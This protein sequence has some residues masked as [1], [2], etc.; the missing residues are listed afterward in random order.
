[1]DFFEFTHEEIKKIFGDIPYLN[2]GGVRHD[3]RSNMF[4][5]DSHAYDLVYK[6][7]SR[8][9]RTLNSEQISAL[10]VY[11]LHALISDIRNGDS[12]LDFR[13]FTEFDNISMGFSTIPILSYSQYKNK[14]N[15]NLLDIMSAM[16]VYFGTKFEVDEEEDMESDEIDDA[17]EVYLRKIP[18]RKLL[19]IQSFY[20][21]YIKPLKSIVYTP[22]NN[23]MYITFSSDDEQLYQNNNNFCIDELSISPIPPDKGSIQDNDIL[24]FLWRNDNIRFRRYSP[25]PSVSAKSSGNKSTGNKYALVFDMNKYGMCTIKHFIANTKQHGIKLP[26]RTDVDGDEFMNIQDQM[27][28][29]GG[30]LRIDDTWKDYLNR[31]DFF[32]ESDKMPIFWDPINGVW[33]MSTGSKVIDMD[34]YDVDTDGYKFLTGRSPGE[35]LTKRFVTDNIY[36]VPAYITNIDGQEIS[37]GVQEETDEFV[38]EY[39]GETLDLY[40]LYE[41][42]F[43]HKH[44]N[45]NE[46]HRLISKYKSLYKFI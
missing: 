29:T 40:D 36:Y 10:A 28:D 35:L 26:S 19:E 7:V 22:S 12:R 39:R 21:K 9:A 2:D 25:N 1:M 5:H 16:N 45:I 38:C 37:I 8:I 44:P 4:D 6:S 41:L 20:N 31:S 11:Y 18:D 14:N 13:V 27:E 3:R 23:N 43:G 15:I 42:V 17:N 34:G 33:V 46:S 32:V 30:I 24:H